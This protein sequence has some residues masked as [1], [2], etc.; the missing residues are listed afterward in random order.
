MNFF[1]Q[2][3]MDQ[4]YLY[5]CLHLT[6]LSAACTQQHLIQLGIGVISTLILTIYPNLPYSLFLVPRITFW[7]GRAFTLLQLEEPTARNR[8]THLEDLDLLTLDHLNECLGG[9]TRKRLGIR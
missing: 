1:Y 3:W 8:P 9:T 6:L 5:L 4:P 7:S 2:H